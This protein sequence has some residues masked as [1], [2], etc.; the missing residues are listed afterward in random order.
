MDLVRVW[1]FKCRLVHV[2]RLPKECLDQM[3]NI[4]DIMFAASERDLQGMSVCFTYINY[5]TSLCIYLDVLKTCMSSH[6]V[7]N[8][9]ARTPVVKS[10]YLFNDA[11][12]T[13][14]SNLLCRL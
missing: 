6:A 1:I 8:L 4:K 14:A 5:A 2:G 13:A 11:V 9:G 10:T 3:E 12:Q 7:T